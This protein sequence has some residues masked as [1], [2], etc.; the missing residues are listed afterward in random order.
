MTIIERCLITDRCKVDGDGPLLHSPYMRTLLMH[1]VTEMS[2]MMNQE[3]G[4][5]DSPTSFI[6]KE[7]SRRSSANED[8]TLWLLE[9][10]M[11]HSRQ[12]NFNEILTVLS[13][14]LVTDAPWFFLW[15]VYRRVSWEITADRDVG[16]AGWICSRFYEVKI[17]WSR[18]HSSSL[19]Y[20][21]SI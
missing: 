13:K 3:Q 2:P 18:R 14:N 17:T 9:F 21:V 12:M 16:W 1:R 10:Y 15:R 5:D 7:R 4:W 6:I 8:P 11:F 20:D 19:S